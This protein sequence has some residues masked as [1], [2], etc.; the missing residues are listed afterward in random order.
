MWGRRNARSALDLY[1]NNTM[2]FFFA[3]NTVVAM[4]YNQAQVQQGIKN[5][6]EQVRS[7]LRPTPEP[8]QVRVSPPCTPGNAQ[9]TREQVENESTHLPL[10]TF[11]DEQ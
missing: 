1:P 4:F 8:T 10:K 7:V 6:Q 3:T 11:A 5:Y 9:V 2:C